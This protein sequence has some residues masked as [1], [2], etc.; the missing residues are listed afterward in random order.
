MVQVHFSAQNIQFKMKRKIE[1]ATA[2]TV[3]HTPIEVV[4]CGK[5]YISVSPTLATLVRVSELIAELPVLDSKS[6]HI[7]DDSMREV[8][9]CKPVAKILAT[10]ILGEKKG[11][12]FS[13]D[14]R[15]WNKLVEDIYFHMSPAQIKAA[16]PDLMSS[17][18]IADFFQLTAS[19]S[20]INL[21][22]TSREAEMTQSGR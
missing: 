1:K 3:L 21:I 20:E 11:R 18:Q 8:K 13:K 22:R 15:K 19:L 2:N 9:N 7:L 6:E 17:M 16:T 5:K 12:L 10:L 14:K 4:V